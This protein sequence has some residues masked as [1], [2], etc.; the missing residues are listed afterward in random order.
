M[1]ARRDPAG[2]LGPAFCRRPAED[3][4]RGLLGAWLVSTIGGETA[5]GRIVECEAYLGPHDP[6]SHAAERIGRTARNAAMFGPAGRAY[7]YRIYGL[8]WCLN[9]VTGTVDVPAA[10]LIRAIAPV[11]GMAVMRTRRSARP[12]LPDS[13][14]GRGPGHAACALGITG[15]LDGHALQRPPLLLARGQ[16]VP[17]TDVDRGPRV[18]VTRAK[19]WPLRFWVRAHPAVSRR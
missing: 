10:V 19:D 17:D 16:P 3:V 14:L 5:I 13:A 12:E 4:A 7:V 9:V 8:H 11:E 1:T 18:G 2:A 15:A 6:A